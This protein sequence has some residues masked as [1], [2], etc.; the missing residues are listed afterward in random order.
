VVGSVEE[1]VV[2]GKKDSWLLEPGES[3][4]Y[5]GVEGRDDERGGTT[6]SLGVIRRLNV[7]VGGIEIGEE[8]RRFRSGRGASSDDIDDS[9]LHDRDSAGSVAVK[10]N[11]LSSGL[12]DSEDL[13]AGATTSLRLFA[14]LWASLRVAFEPE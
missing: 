1:G 13:S 6:V 14:S 9:S 3:N 11:F 4:L 7:E 5:L 12:L 8:G 2:E 10:V